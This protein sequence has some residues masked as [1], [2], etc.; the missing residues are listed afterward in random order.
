MCLERTQLCNGIPD[1]AS[2][3]DESFTTCEPE[4]GKWLIL[5]SV[6]G[7]GSNRTIEV[8]IRVIHSLFI[9][10]DRCGHSPCREATVF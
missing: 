9:Q 8:S 3:L 4:P 10:Q 6:E 7:A 5:R 1:C 2:G